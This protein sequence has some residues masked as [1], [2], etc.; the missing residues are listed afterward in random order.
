MYNEPTALRRTPGQASLTGGL[1]DGILHQQNTVS[2]LIVKQV[3][4][5]MRISHVI[6]VNGVCKY[7][8]N[9][10][11]EIILRR[12]DYQE[13]K[14][15]KKDFKNL[16]PND[17]EDLFLLNIQEKLNHLPKTDNTSLHMA[18]NMWIRNLVIRNHVGD[19][20]LEI[21]IYQTK[22]NL[23]RPNWDAVFGLLLQRSITIGMETRKWIRM[24]K[25]RKQ[26]LHHCE[27]GKDTDQEDLLESRKLCWR[28]IRDIDTG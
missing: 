14:I 4:S 28:R 3:R 2:T 24:N 25:R 23:E 16:H 17:F 21:E 20:Q 9:Y 19:L 10:L 27:R 1:E 15:S 6:S 22:I 26:R 8:Y 11:K 13:Y 7:G 5:Q 18:V 12:A